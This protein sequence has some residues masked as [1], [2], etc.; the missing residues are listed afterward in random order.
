MDG[1]LTSFKPLDYSAAS[2]VIQVPVLNFPW[3]SFSYMKI[4]SLRAQVFA[5]PFR[6]LPIEFENELGFNRLNQS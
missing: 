3:Y 4:A 1:E 2:T 5:L 6:L